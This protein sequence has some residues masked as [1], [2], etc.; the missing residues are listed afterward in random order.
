[1]LFFVVL[2]FSHIMD[3]V[4]NIPSFVSLFQNQTFYFQLNLKAERRRKRETFL[5]SIPSK[6]F[7]GL[8]VMM[9]GPLK[10]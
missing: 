1:M 4:Y 10:E 8:S 9:S 3:W 7:S 5:L 6:E 2:T